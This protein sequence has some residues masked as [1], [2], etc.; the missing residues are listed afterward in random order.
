MN[1]KENGSQSANPSIRLEFLPDGNTQL[2]TT[3][4]IGPNQLWAASHLLALMGDSQFTEAQ[5]VAQAKHPRLAIPG[6]IK[7]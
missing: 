3:P 5:L 4:G 1:E 7:S 2:Q 6:R